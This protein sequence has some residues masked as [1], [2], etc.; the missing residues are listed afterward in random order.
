MAVELQ[1]GSRKT[2]DEKPALPHAS[3]PAP[4][5][6]LFI[7]THALVES[8]FAM[9]NLGLVIIDEQHK[10]GVSQRARLTARDPAP[11]VDRK[12]VV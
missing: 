6:S 1:T 9:P 4:R 3:R 8:P 7:G 5:A 11:D 2:R 10:F 12:S